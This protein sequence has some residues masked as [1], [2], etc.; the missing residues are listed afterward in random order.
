MVQWLRLCTPNAES[1]GSISGW[2]TKI[3][4]ATQPKKERLQINNIA[5]YLKELEKEEQTENETKG[6]KKKK[7]KRL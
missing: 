7:K 3:I 6:A 1:I 4:H 5:S 2:G